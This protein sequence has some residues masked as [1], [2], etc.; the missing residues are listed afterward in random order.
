M[1]FTLHLFPP[2]IRGPSATFKL[3]NLPKEIRLSILEH[4][5]SGVL[6]SVPF[7]LTLCGQSSKVT[8]L[9]PPCE[10]K[11]NPKARPC[12]LHFTPFSHAMLRVNRE[13]REDY[14]SV[15]RHECNLIICHCTIFKHYEV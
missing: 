13:L 6:I 4:F 3:F 2:S 11:G 8:L 10:Y 1:E 7:Y 14:I 12:R 15:L 5:C 9:V